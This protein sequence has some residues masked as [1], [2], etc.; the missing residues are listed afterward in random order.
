MLTFSWWFSWTISVYIHVYLSMW[1]SDDNVWYDEAG[2]F[3]FVFFSSN[4]KR[5]TEVVSHHYHPNVL[6]LAS[7]L[8]CVC[9]RI[10]K[11][12]LTS[13]CRVPRTHTY[14]HHII[15]KIEAIG[16]LRLD[17]RSDN[18]KETLY[19][20]ACFFYVFVGLQRRKEI[21]KEKHNIYVYNNNNNYGF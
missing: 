21:S 14:T 20:H 17:L 12:F 9:M 6:L 18:W 1:H 2:A 8:A 5:I 15:W 3:F 7:C 16:S 11:C 13:W 19:R 10:T 4:N